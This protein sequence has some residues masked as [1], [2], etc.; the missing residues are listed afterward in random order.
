M[1]CSAAFLFSGTPPGAAGNATAPPQRSS[2]LPLAV[3]RQEHELHKGSGNR[4]M[5]WVTDC[6]NIVGSSGL[7]RAPRPVTAR[8]LCRAILGMNQ[9]S[10]GASLIE[11]RCGCHATQ[12]TSTSTFSSAPPSMAASCGVGCEVCG[13][14]YNLRDAVSA[15]RVGESTIRVDAVACHRFVVCGRIVRCIDAFS[16][17]SV[18][19]AAGAAVSSAPLTMVPYD[20]FWLSDTTG[21]VCV[22]RL[23]PG[24][25][26]ISTSLSASSCRCDGWPIVPVCDWRTSHTASAM[27][28]SHAFAAADA[29]G[30]APPSPRAPRC[31]FLANRSSCSPTPE[32][33]LCCT[34]VC[35]RDEAHKG[36]EYG[37]SVA[38]A[39]T[40]IGLACEDD[41]ALCVND[42]AVCIGTLAFA[43]VDAHVR[44]A[45]QPYASDIRQ[46]TWAAATSS[47]SSA[48]L[49]S[50]G[51]GSCSG[52]D[53][54][55]GGVGCGACGAS[56]D[57]PVIDEG[58]AGASE[59]P[60]SAPVP[61]SR[62]QFVLLPGSEVP[63][64]LDAARGK[65]GV[66]GSLPSSTRYLTAAEVTEWGGTPACAASTATLLRSSAST[67]HGHGGEANSAA[68]IDR[69]SST[70][71]CAATDMNEIPLVSIKGG[72]RLVSDTNE[73]MF[74]WLSAVEAHVRWSRRVPAP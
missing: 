66:V 37:A 62:E 22:L 38:E 30:P 43:D 32:G 18:A 11:E 68:V 13:D 24:L 16:N 44:H 56:R 69:R 57:T 65:L 15:A 64:T 48:H 70:H 33:R 42:Y 9:L 40:N 51:A 67:R 8:Q 45:L 58:G 41:Y 34:G 26:H 29:G 7:S 47:W 21:V 55:S 60:R 39:M 49:L 35:N 50:A 6:S 36:I 74:W 20:L 12:G 19:A 71:A 73:C 46:A 54:E 72:L 2:V 3:A 59:Q 1:R 61:P 63:L 53:A 52:V 5:R 17:G 27:A 23:R 31:A 25:A 10:G 14:G 28:V 4:G